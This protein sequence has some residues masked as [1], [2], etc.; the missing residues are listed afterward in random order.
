MSKKLKLTGK[1]IKLIR[2]PTQ[3]EWTREGWDSS[4][5]A[6]KNTLVIELE[7]GTL[8]WP[9]DFAGDEPGSFIVSDGQTRGKHVIP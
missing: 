6:S 7:D 2:R 8:I 1:T 4:D 3:K 5:Q 9:A